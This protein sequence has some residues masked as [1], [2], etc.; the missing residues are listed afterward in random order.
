MNPGAAPTA[1]LAGNRSVDT[2]SELTMA[3]EHSPKM[4]VQMAVCHRSPSGRVRGP[5]RK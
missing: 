5:K 3:A 2:A 1:T 4:A